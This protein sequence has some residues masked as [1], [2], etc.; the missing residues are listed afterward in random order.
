[1]GAPGVNGRCAQGEKPIGVDS[2][3]GSAGA[4]S[5]SPTL[6]VVEAGDGVPV[7]PP[8]HLD[9]EQAHQQPE[10]QQ[11]EEGGPQ[12]LGL[13]VRQELLA[14]PGESPQHARGGLPLG[15]SGVGP[16][17]SLRRHQNPPAARTMARP[18]RAQR[19]ATNPN[20]TVSGSSHAHALEA[21]CKPLP[22]ERVGVRFFFASPLRVP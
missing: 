3:Q 19:C 8:G 21:T 6:L 7:D 11:L 13:P 18:T 17:L 12:V 20:K 10:Q 9:A 14:E 4:S 1:M 2:A 15:G 22:A 16:G 5:G